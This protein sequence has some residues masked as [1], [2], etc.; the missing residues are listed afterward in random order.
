MTGEAF[1]RAVTGMV[2]TLYRVSCSQLSIEADRK[3]PSRRPCGGHGKSAL[4]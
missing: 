3:T 2:Q 4:P 1:E